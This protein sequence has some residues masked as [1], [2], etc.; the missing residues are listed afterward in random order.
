M[1]NLM[2]AMVATEL[3]KQLFEIARKLNDEGRA[4]E[5]DC[6][7]AAAVKL[8]PSPLPTYAKTE[9]G[10]PGIFYSTKYYG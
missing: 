10:A 4:D 1:R 5:A 3:H 2:E 9:W 8:I 7:R 6:V